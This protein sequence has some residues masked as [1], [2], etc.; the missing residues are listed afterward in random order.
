MKKV[1]K[2]TL[3]GTGIVVLLVAAFYCVFGMYYQ[4]GFPCFTWVN[5]V[6]CTGKTVAMV[7]QELI[8]KEPYTGIALIDKSGASLYI[9]AEDAGYSKDYTYALTD[10]LKT[11]NP[12]AWGLYAFDDTVYHVE[13]TIVID[14]DKVNKLISQWEIFEEPNDVPCRISKTADG[15][16]LENPTVTVPVEEKIA[17]RVSSAIQS[18]VTVIDLASYDDCYKDVNLSSGEKKKMDL[19]AKINS[20]QKMSVTYTVG[21]DEVVFGSGDISNAILTKDDY[22]K[23]LEEKP[24]SKVLG[25]GRYIIAGQEAE[26]PSE[27]EVN[28]LEDIAVDQGGNPIVSEKK[29]YAFF[30][31]VAEKYGTKNLMD[32]YRKGLSNTVI[33][34]DSSKGNGSIFDINSEFE[35][36]RDKLMDGDDS[37]P[38]KREFAL[39]D[40]ATS[41]DAK[42]SLGDTYIEINMGDQELRYY[43]DGK[44]DMAFP[45]VTGNINRGRGTPAGVYNIYNK[46]YHTYLRGADYVSYVNYWLGVHKGIGIHDALW[47]NKFGEEIYKSDGSHGCINCPLDSIETLWNT[48]EIGTPVILYY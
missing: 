44:L 10:F 6:Y 8:K 20:L 31:D 7:N 43:V 29:I 46:R 16:V 34:N 26:L 32:M 39:S 2:G 23:A 21:D 42:K 33:V 14:G 13:P 19:F 17:E 35:H 37:A 36:L 24:G 18:G 27:D 11:R 9:S 40:T 5:G 1:L 30:E 48:A 47:R 38:E 45:I 4:G 15:Y 41:I 22:E 28:F 3:I 12:M 25:A